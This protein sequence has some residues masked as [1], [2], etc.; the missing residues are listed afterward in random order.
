[1][2]ADLPASTRRSSRRWW[3]VAAS[4]AGGEFV[5]VW[6]AAAV[7]TFVTQGICGDPASTENLHTARWLLLVLSAAAFLPW[8]L[9][10]YRSVPRR[11]VALLVGLLA[12]APAVRVAVDAVLSSPAEWTNSYCVF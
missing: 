12:A 4:A 2:I 6:L 9:V 3:V 7:A 1:M 5:V 10:A 8:A 11:P